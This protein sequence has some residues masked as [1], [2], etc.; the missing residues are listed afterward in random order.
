MS[1]P[2]EQRHVD[3]LR[4]AAWAA[5]SASSERAGTTQHTMMED[6]T[7]ALLVADH[8]LQA[9]EIIAGKRQPLDNLMSNVD[10]AN[11]ALEWSPPA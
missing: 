10:V 11:A 5:G 6:I 1:P 9:L 7:K 8:H 2:P 4:L 3:L